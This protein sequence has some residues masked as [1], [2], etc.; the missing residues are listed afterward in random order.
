MYG[1]LPIFQHWCWFFPNFISIGHPIR[2][3]VE[4]WV[5]N[6]YTYITLRCRGITQSYIEIL[7]EIIWPVIS[8]SLKHLVNFHFCRTIINLFNSTVYAKYSSTPLRNKVCFCLIET[9]LLE[10][11]KTTICCSQIS[12]YLIIKTSRAHMCVH[13]ASHSWGYAAGPEAVLSAGVQA[14]EPHFCPQAARS[15]GAA[16]SDWISGRMVLNMSHCVL[17]ALPC[18]M[19]PFLS[20]FHTNSGET[21][22]KGSKTAG[23][24]FLL[25]LFFSLQHRLLR[26][27][28]AGLREAGYKLHAN[29]KY[30]KSSLSHLAGAWLR[31]KRG[32]HS[33]NWVAWDEGTDMG[34]H[35]K[36]SRNHTA[37]LCNFFS[38][39]PC[40]AMRSIIWPPS[41]GLAQLYIPLK[42]REQTDKS[43]N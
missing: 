39:R 1:I 26:P 29:A 14:Q 34:S 40:W 27:P 32:E 9:A 38:P 4:G 33:Q 11:V 3:G 35:G 23:E 2:L 22:L 25:L 18:Y 6:A 8:V 17:F 15:H 20:G 13:L 37:I 43:T 30:W 42:T 36:D 12:P 41:H 28:K 16:A 24:L 21:G 19:W 10:V 7:V 31:G 5:F